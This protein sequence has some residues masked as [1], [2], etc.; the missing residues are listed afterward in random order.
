MHDVFSLQAYV[1]VN[2]TNLFLHYMQV[3][4]LCFM[5][6]CSYS[7][8]Q[9]THLLKLAANTP[10]SSSLTSH[11]LTKLLLHKILSMLQI[12]Q[13]FCSPNQL[14]FMLLNISF[15][16]YFFRF[17]WAWPKLQMCVLAMSWELVTSQLLK[18]LHFWPW[19]FKVNIK[20]AV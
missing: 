2:K 16:F 4:F 9:Q 1:D 6:T 7:F 14:L 11:S 10:V 12:W 15:C 3:S 5:H 18:G 8:L 17:L 19:D 20:C 13:P